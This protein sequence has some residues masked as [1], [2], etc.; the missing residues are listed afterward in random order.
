VNPA[1]TRTFWVEPVVPRP[2]LV[3]GTKLRVELD[4]IVDDRGRGPHVV[5]EAEVFEGGKLKLSITTVSA[6]GRA[7]VGF[8]ADDI[9]DVV[10]WGSTPIVRLR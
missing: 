4:Q 5:G 6:A 9:L 2:G 1:T 10:L 8:V 3:P 7:A